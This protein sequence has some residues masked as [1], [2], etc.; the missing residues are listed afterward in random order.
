MLTDE[1]PGPCWAFR[2]L[3]TCYNVDAEVPARPCQGR[4]RGTRS[5]RLP[6]RD[7][8]TPSI[9]APEIWCAIPGLEG[10]YDV[11]DQGRVR[12]LRFRGGRVD[13]PRKTPLILRPALS[14]FGYWHVGIDRRA[15]QNHLLVLEAFVGP[16]PI[17]Q[18]AAHLNGVRTDNRRENL[19]WKTRSENAMGQG[20]RV[21]GTRRARIRIAC[22][23]GTSIGRIRGP[24]GCGGG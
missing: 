2:R 5:W 23:A 17:G 7:E 3:S 24:I 12:S 15:R 19:A 1:R 11:S 21:T 9:S 10:R 20:S 18:E 8:S 4:R 6:V 22:I 16:R 14:K 13:V